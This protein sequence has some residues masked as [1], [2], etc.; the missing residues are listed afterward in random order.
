MFNT[1]PVAAGGLK[2]GVYSDVRGATDFSGY[3]LGRVAIGA[4]AGN[5]YILPLSRGTNGQVM[6]T[7][8]AGNASWQ[9]P[10]TFAWGLN[11]NAGTNPTTN[12]IGTTDNV[13]LIF[14]RNSETI[15]R[16]RF[17]NV[18]FGRNSLTNLTTGSF[19]VA[20]GTDSL[21]TL[22]TGSNN[23]AIGINTL[24]NNLTGNGNIAIVG[25]ALRDLQ[26]GMG[27]IAIGNQ[28]LQSSI[29]SNEAIA[30]GSRALMLHN[31]TI[32]V[33]RNIAI[34]EESLYSSQGVR[35]VSLGYQAGYGN[36]EGNN[37]TFIGTNANVLNSNLNYAVAIGSGAVVERSNAIALGGNTPFTNTRV[38]I[39]VSNPLFSLHINQIGAF[40]LG[41]SNGT[42]SWEFWNNNTLRMYYNGIQRGN[43]NETNG[44]Y[45]SISDRKLKTNIQPLEEI[46]SKLTK[47][48]PSS[49]TFKH[50]NKNTKQIGL[51]AQEVEEIFPEFVYKSTNSE[52]QEV[53][54]YTLDYSGM[55]VIAIKAIQEQQL[56]IEKQ[57]A[58]IA[59][60]KQLEEQ[61][62]Q[63]VQRLESLEKNNVWKFS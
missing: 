39:N 22:T 15:G 16:L 57:Q 34:G 33:S 24:R 41:L 38:G 12:F 2:Y 30:I 13:D 47:L 37:N 1:F 40:G 53:E 55:S 56:I 45:T 29:N 61:V 23:I 4:T 46:L 42:N 62:Q 43:F 49:Y 8:G 25:N 19:N 60:L 59:R 11:G 14:R 31:S 9:S 44:V 63:L 28:A 21:N 36:I 26:S 17:D 54:L 51:I 50:D 20:L 5:N 7:D 10:T 6:Q 18:T 35:N 58:E 32:S 27:N 52:R 3:F 48:K